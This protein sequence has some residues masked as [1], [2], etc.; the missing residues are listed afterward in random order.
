VTYFTQQHEDSL[1]ICI[2][3]FC[4]QEK[5]VVRHAIGMARHAAG[6]RADGRE[7]GAASGEIS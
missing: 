5:V 2:N 7:R 1:D 6:V 3:K 4:G